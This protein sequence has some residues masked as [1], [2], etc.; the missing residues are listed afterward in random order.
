VNTKRHLFL[1]FVTA[2]ATA[3]CGGGGSSDTTST[4]PAPVVNAN[5]YPSMLSNAGDWFVYTMTVTPTLPAG[6]APT[7]R[8][9]TRY[10]RIVNTDGSLTRADTTSSFNSLAS[11]AFNTAG[12]LVSYT[13]GTFLCNYAPAY[14][15]GP[16]LNSLVGDN[17][18]SNATES[19]ATQPNGAATTSAL[20]TSGTNQPNETRSIPV[21]TFSTFKYSQTLITTSATATTTTL[22]T[23]WIDKVTG[24]TVECTSSYS[25]T[26]TG[27]ASATSSGT[28]H[29]RLEGYSFK[30][31]TA[32][33][34]AVR[35]FAGYWNVNFTGTS[36]GDCANLLIDINGQIS[37]SCRFLTSAGVYGTPFN[38]SG[39]VAGNGT[40]TV[41]ATTGASLS[42][43]FTSP[44]D[45][46]GSWTNGAATGNWNATHI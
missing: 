12:A 13:S 19:C 29:F 8:T 2:I 38:V 6:T 5:A 27:Q 31:Q 44:I 26:P 20:S 9:I 46:N 35:R 23:C 37:G 41:T 11:R 40:A 36:T 25:T 1:C 15:S 32:V 4:T 7:E 17:Y 3:S 16:G 14:R 33:G 28:N 24:R 21:G 30:G 10:F 34:T 39:S 18:N 45:A 42:G 43:T 22:E